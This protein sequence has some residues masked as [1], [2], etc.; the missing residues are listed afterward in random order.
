MMG[1]LVIAALASR[2]RPLSNGSAISGH[3][4]GMLMIAATVVAAA[5]IIALAIESHRQGS[6]ARRQFGIGGV[7]FALVLIAAVTAGSYG[8]GRV[9][10]PSIGSRPRG[11][12]CLTYERAR[13]R[14]TSNC[15]GPVP[16]SVVKRAP[17]RGQARPRSSWFVIGGL[18]ALLGGGGVLLATGRRRQHSSRTEPDNRL[19]AIV[20][21]VDLSIDDL[22]KEANAKRAIIA[23]YARME[24]AFTGM[25]LPRRPAEAP[26]EFLVRSLQE[27][28]AGRKAASRLTELFELAKFSHHTVTLSMR[29]EA[30]G[31]LVAIRGELADQATRGLVA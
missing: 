27:D 21:A 11:V 20:N 3:T 16:V 28:D 18:I 25:G 8:L 26:H 9:F 4:A 19:G 24:T 29:D 1:L 5:L 15:A 6:T 12:L 7:L 2:A 31:A 30:I 14:P 23:A 22:L 17:R 13:D 10:N